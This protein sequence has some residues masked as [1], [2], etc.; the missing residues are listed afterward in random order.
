ML[1]LYVVFKYRI[2][3]VEIAH[4]ILWNVAAFYAAC[5]ADVAVNSNYGL[6]YRAPPV[7]HISCL[8]TLLRMAL[9]FVCSCLN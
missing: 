6:T 3:I 8:N 1:E 7:I 2:S 5:V 9:H 4:G